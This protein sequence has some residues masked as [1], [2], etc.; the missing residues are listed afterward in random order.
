[1]STKGTDKGGYIN[2]GTYVVNKKEISEY[3]SDIFSFEKDF[4]EKFTG[5]FKA[6][7]HDNFFIDIGIP[8]DYQRACKLLS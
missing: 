6:Y 1:M 5:T 3:K 2:S 4:I 8:K 7:V